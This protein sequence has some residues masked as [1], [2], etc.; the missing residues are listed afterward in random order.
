MGY[1]MGVS[2]KGPFLIASDSCYAATLQDRAHHGPRHSAPGGEPRVSETE[3]PIPCH[4][5]V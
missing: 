5:E 3:G 1:R 4:F 2:P